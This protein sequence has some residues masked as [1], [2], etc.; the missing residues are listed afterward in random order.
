MPL[1][2][3]TTSN[4]DL[5]TYVVD[6]TPDGQL[7]VAGSVYQD[8]S[9]QNRITITRFSASG[10]YLIAG[11]S[12]GKLAVL[13]YPSM[14]SLFPPL[15]V[16]EILD[17]DIQT[18]HNE[19]L[20]AVASS[21]AI[22]LINVRTGATIEVIQSPMLNQTTAGTFAAC[23]PVFTI[24]ISADN[25]FMAS[26]AGK[27]LRVTPLRKSISKGFDYASPIYVFLSM[28]MFALFAHILVLKF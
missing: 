22:Q 6:V 11:F 20:L 17:V 5:S 2:K 18:I 19:E 23:R 3:L 8:S 14:T 10:Q 4:T 26:A 16:G 25:S 28:L 27:Q 12:D 13:R 15:T 21:K 1:K 9:V 7:V 24:T